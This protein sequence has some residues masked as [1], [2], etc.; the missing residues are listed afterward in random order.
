MNPRFDLFFVSGVNQ[1]ELVSGVNPRFSC[2]TQK[3]KLT[4][5]TFPSRVVQ[6]IVCDG[7]VD[8]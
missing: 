1:G 8:D 6:F 3:I 7:F 5:K 2:A 4:V